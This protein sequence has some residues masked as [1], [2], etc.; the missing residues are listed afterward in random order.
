MSKQH[1]DLYFEIG[2]EISELVEDN[3]EY[4]LILGPLNEEAE[5]IYDQLV[6]TT[7]PLQVEEINITIGPYDSIEVL[8]EGANSTGEHN[9]FFYNPE[10]AE[11][12]VCKTHG[13]PTDGSLSQTSPLPD[14]T[15]GEYF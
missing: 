8:L 11:D 4:D 12:T 2:Q 13:K 3:K 6:D 1:D 5:N 14:G 7:D 15:S 10:N 9:S